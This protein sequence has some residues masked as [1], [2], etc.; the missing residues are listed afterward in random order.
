VECLEDR[1]VLTFSFA[2]PI[3]LPAFNPQGVVAA[4]FNGDGKTDLAV[5][6]GLNVAPGQVSVQVGQGNGTFVSAGAPIP[7]GPSNVNFIRSLTAADLDGD[8]K[9]D[10]ITGNFNSNTITVLENTTPAPGATPT[11]SA[12]PPISLGSGSRGPFWVIAADLDGDGKQ[13]LVVASPQGGGVIVLRNTSTGPGNFSFAQS[14]FPIPGSARAVEAAD[15]DGDGK[16]DL[17]TAGSSANTLSVLRNTSTGPGNINFV[18]SATIS[19]PGTTPSALVLADFYGD[20]KPALAFTDQGQISP[21][22]V[23]VLPNQ[24]LI[25]GGSF[26]NATKL[27]MSQNFSQA[28]ALVSGDFNGDGN[29][30]LAVATTSPN[31]FVFYGL[32][33]GSFTP[34]ETYT[35]PNY[36]SPI[37]VQ[38]K[39]LASGDFNGDGAPD[40]VLSDGS[41]GFNGESILLNQAA[42][43]A[44]QVTPSTPTPAE[45]SPFTVTVTATAN[46]VPYVNYRGTVTLTSNDPLAPTLGTHTFTPSDKGTYTFTVSL[47]SPGPRTVTASDGTING[48]APVTVQGVPPTLGNV[49]IT[50]STIVAGSPTTLTGTISAPNSHDPFTLV[51][52]WGD[53]SPLQTFNY[54]PGTTAFSQSHVYLTAGNYTVGVA[55]GDNERGGGTLYGSDTSRNLFTLNLATGAATPVGTLPGNGLQVTEIAYDNFG[56]AAWLQYGGTVFEGQQFNIANAAGIGGPIANVPG[57]TFT[58]MTY[59]GSILYASGITSTGGTAPSDLRVLDPT[60]GHS[61]LIG[62]TG[63]NGPMAGL[64]YDPAA[65]V[66]YGLEGGQH[67][68]NNLFTLNLATGAATPIFSTGFA[69]GSLAF[70]PDGMLYAGSN[71]GQLY[72]INLAGHSVSLVGTSSTTA[73][74][75]LAVVNLVPPTTTTVGVTVQA[76]SVANV[77][78]QFGNR[79]ASLTNVTRD[80]P[81]VNISAI[82]IVFTANVVVTQSD[83]TLAGV[84]VPS[85]AIAGFS[86]NALTKTATWTLAPPLGADRLTLTLA[87]VHDANGNALAGGTFVQRFSVLPGDVNG[88]GV[89]DSRDMVGVRNEM[90]GLSPADIWGDLNGDGIVDMNDYNLVRRHINTRLP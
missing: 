2:T 49:Q 8:G 75:G 11:F 45:G 31:V 13:D 71:T 39:M 53:G 59:D 44:L 48:S 88:D 58:G 25:Q 19:V 82:E 6:S 30:D 24:D 28:F 60:T 56:Q 55:L 33:N 73:L 69:G 84:N 15:I 22:A 27:V 12:L 37:V 18:V 35:S 29:T 86:Y 51:V 52:N 26:P 80:L 7:V 43:T 89:V 68:T 76:P 3:S 64:A 17:V 9:P 16:L 72:R 90:M 63:V 50:P 83:L 78:V 21:G 54:P 34:P 36:T 32:G 70:G 23:Y 79:T 87:G 10:I 14:F 40:L 5:G 57:E 1:L 42:A 65:G 38:P 20:N 46:G 4:D 85:Y 81:W 47:P 74:S 67:T 62:M 66:L 77:L 61:T 41:G